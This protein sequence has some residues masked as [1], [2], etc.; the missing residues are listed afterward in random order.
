CPDEIAE[1]VKSG[2]AGTVADQVVPGG[3]EKLPGDVRARTTE[4]NQIQGDN[5]VLHT[6]R[7]AGDVVEA[8]ADVSNVLGD[9]AVE[10]HGHI[11]VDSPA[12]G[13]GGIA[14]NRAIAQPRG[15]GDH[16]ATR[17]GRGVIVDGTIDQGRR[18]GPDTAAGASRRRVVADGAGT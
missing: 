5:R 8:A 16:A 3:G 6:E 7:G 15:R 18:A 9:G 4:I 11:G 13:A 10:Q 2:P 1:V 14:G 12:L 17:E